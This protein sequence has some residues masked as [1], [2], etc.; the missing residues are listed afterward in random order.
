MEINIKKIVKHTAIYFLLIIGYIYLYAID[1][2]TVLN[3]GKE[4]EVKS[5]V[6]FIYQQF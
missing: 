5:K 3:P 1:M 2:D 4:Q 6:D